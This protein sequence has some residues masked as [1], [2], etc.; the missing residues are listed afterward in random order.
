M[1][2]PEAGQSSPLDQTAYTQPALFALEYALA[3]LWRSWG[4]KPSVVMGH[5]VGEY[6]AACVAG[7]FSLE[8]G[9]KLIAARARL[10]QALPAG[11]RM[12]AVFADEA[13]V[14]RAIAPY[15]KTV[16][17]A[18]VNGP[19]NMVISGVGS[20]VEAVLKRF[21]A[22]GIGF[23]PLTVSHAFHSPLMEPMLDE[24][25]RV[26]A[27]VTYASPRIGLVSNVSGTLARGEEMANGAY[28]RRHIRQPVRFSAS[29]EWLYGQGYRMFMEIG[30]SPV[31]LGMGA[32]CFP[33]GESCLAAFAEAGG[34]GLAADADQFGRALR[35]RC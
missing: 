29:M 33:E 22:E 32:R 12:A 16:S 24:F 34:G 6:V 13:R 2:Y 1:L 27:E 14:V 25:E 28:W 7:V 30:P 9:L 19:E 18:C 4:I 15:R 26:A 8:D 35:A 21:E 10:M 3:E 23:T 17:L 5:S 31:L 11:G 20:D